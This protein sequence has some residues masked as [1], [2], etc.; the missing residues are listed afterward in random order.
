MT[1]VI[2]IGKDIITKDQL[3]PLLTNYQMLPYLVRERIID[4]AIAEIEC[5]EA[6]IELACSQL[7][8]RYQLKDEA[9]KQEWLVRHQ[10]DRQKFI[11]IA[12]RSLKLQKFQEQTWGNCLP[13]YFLERKRQLDRLAYSTIWVKDADLAQELYFR[14]SEG[15]ESFAELAKQYSE[16][17][18]AELGGLVGLVEINSVPASFRQA[19]THSQEKKVA[20]P[21]KIG[22]WIALFRLETRVQARLDGSMRQRLLNELFNKWL[23]GQMKTRGYRLEEVENYWL[24]AS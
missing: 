13:T 3:I 16:G 8:Q 20:F 4:E 15:E 7:A 22:E 23:Q 12:T 19:L 10:S 5:T 21:M 17:L 9:A 1:T 14:L 6:E 2:E 24:N 18:E 11:Q